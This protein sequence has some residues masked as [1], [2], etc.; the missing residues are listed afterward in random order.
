MT[1]C[2]S[3][4]C[5]CDSSDCYLAGCDRKSELVMDI[6]LRSC[7]RKCSTKTMTECYPITPRETFIADPE[8]NYSDVSRENCHDSVDNVCKN[9]YLDHCNSIYR[10]GYRDV[11]E[12]SLGQVPHEGAGKDI[13]GCVIT[14]ERVNMMEERASVAQALPTEDCSAILSKECITALM[15]QYSPEVEAYPSY[16]PFYM[17]ENKE[18]PW[19]EVKPYYWDPGIAYMHCQLS[20]HHNLHLDEFAWEEVNTYSVASDGLWDNIN[21]DEVLDTQA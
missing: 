17:G 19:K 11:L 15:S 16:Q 18:F 6:N 2:F 4:V 7:Q 12:V 5:A 9:F 8:E 1:E 21:M 14:Q 10:S 13:H 20:F 3:P